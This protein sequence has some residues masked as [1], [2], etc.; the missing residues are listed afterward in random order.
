MHEDSTACTP[1]GGNGLQQRLQMAGPHD[2][3]TSAVQL[4]GEGQASQRGIAAVRA[5]HDQY[6]GLVGYPLSD[7]PAH[8]VCEVMLHGTGAPLLVP[9]MQ[10]RLAKA[11]GPPASMYH[12]APGVHSA[13]VTG[14]LLPATADELAVEH[15]ENGPVKKG[16]A[17]IFWY[18]QCQ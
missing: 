2:V 1:V 15:T 7:R 13:S 12:L 17:G 9:G 10:V 18:V 16:Q 6:L 11:G 5:P 8:S 14:L 3:H 4:G